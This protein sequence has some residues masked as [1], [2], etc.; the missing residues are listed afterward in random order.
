M[1][2]YFLI[3]LIIFP[4]LHPAGKEISVHPEQGKGGY[5]EPFFPMNEYRENVADPDSL[6]GFSLGSKPASH[7]EIITYFEYLDEEFSNA[8]LYDCGKTYEGRRLVY[9]VI[10]SEKNFSRLDSI[11]DNIAKLSDPRTIANSSEAKK[12]IAHTPAV[13]WMSYSIHGDELSGADAG[14]QLA[15]Q[16]LA[17]TDKYSRLIRDSLV[18]CIDPLQNP[19]GR[20][21]F[22][23]QMTQWN[24]FVV[25]FDTQSAHHRGNWPWG[26]GNHYL[27]DLNR[28]WFTQV[29]PESK[30]KVQAIMEW[31]PQLVVDG[32]EMGP[33]DTYLF[34]PPR[35]PY[36]PFMPELIYKWWKIMSLEHSA[37][38]DQNGWNYYTREW[39]EE[40][41]PGYGSSWSIYTGAVGLLYEQAGV[42]GSQVLQRDGTVLT[43]RESVHHQFISSM[44]NL[45]T[46]ADNRKDLLRDYYSEKHKSVYAKPNRLKAFIFPKGKNVSIEKQFAETLIRQGIEVGQTLQTEKLKQ[47]V[48]SDGTNETNIMIPKGSMLV[49][50]D[51]PNHALVN[52]IL[53]FDIR[54]KNSFLETERRQRLKHSESRMYETTAWSLPLA[55]GLEGYFTDH[56]PPIVTTKYVTYPSPGMVFNPQPYFGYVIP[57]SDHN[58]YALLNVL[59][60]NHLKVWTAKKPFSIN[61]NDFSSGTYLLRLNANPQLTTDFMQA[62]ALEFGVNIYGVN[63]GLVD[64]GPDLG[65]GEFHLL[66]IPKIALV[67]GSPTS[68][69]SFGAAWHLL[70]S[71]INIPFSILEAESFS[72]AD[73]RKYN[74]IV[75]PSSWGGAGAYKRYFGENG[76]EKLKGWIEDGGTVIGL[77]SGSHYLTDSTVAVSSVRQKRQVLKNLKDYE[78]SLEFLKSAEVPEIDSLAVWEGKKQTKSTKQKEPEFSM[79]EIKDKDELAR[80]LAPRGMLMKANVD[81]E[82][83][84]SFGCG[85]YV[86]PMVNTSV[87]LVG[88]EHVSTAARFA[89]ENKLRISGLLWPEARERWAET[90]FASREGYGNGQVILFAVD[91]NFRGYFHNTERMFLN[92]LFLGPG[93]GTHQTIKW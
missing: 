21:R 22:L 67:G 69:Y 54:L 47:A 31:H 90:V 26:R 52:A 40:F 16:L 93:M 10:T 36:N 83:W 59:L 76:I 62:L 12:I 7:D 77:G 1:N 71:R 51:Q 17:G 30:G 44:A 32:H 84:L 75:L 85:E 55:Y 4:F 86:I 25:N 87:A 78:K 57:N 23:A 60:E 11:R 61:G 53:S 29:H 37:A 39:N 13:S 79:N 34:N 89:E 2:R 56:L 24:G 73:L 88:D 65:G 43:Y 64:S 8:K 45:I 50:L 28:D 74:V 20:T 9:L 19:D 35:E 92:A 48:K 5:V 46:V 49:R 91:P 27:F 70:D 41:F 15:F 58:S 33:L 81:K 6:W 68:Y 66:E 18:V 38:F 3:L 14:V 63:S 82:H 80:K 42:D 72:G